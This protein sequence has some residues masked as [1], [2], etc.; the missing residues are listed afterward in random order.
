MKQLI[1]ILLYDMTAKEICEANSKNRDYRFYKKELPDFCLRTNPDGITE[2]E[3][4]YQFYTDVD[5]LAEEQQNERYILFDMYPISSYI[6]E[7]HGQAG[8]DIIFTEEDSNND[9]YNLIKN[10]TEGYFNKWVDRY[11]PTELFLVVDLQF[12]EEE[13]YI[14]AISY[15]DFD[16][17]EININK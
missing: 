11:I 2:S 8:W 16:F 10:L 17:K 14:K 12:T 4:Y 9:L 1:K 7:E 13:A 3:C 5:F 15:L 6:G